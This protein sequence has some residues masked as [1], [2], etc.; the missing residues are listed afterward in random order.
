[1]LLN[2]YLKLCRYGFAYNAS[3]DEVL[4]NLWM[5][6]NLFSDTG[7]NFLDSNFIKGL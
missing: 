3:L 2:E 6:E 1:M 5:D 4:K 7:I